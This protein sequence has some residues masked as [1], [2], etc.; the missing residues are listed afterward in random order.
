[1]SKAWL[2]DLEEKVQEAATRL[3]DQKAVSQELEQQNLKLQ[4]RVEELE[5]QLAD[6]GDGDPSSEWQEERQEIR[7]RVEKL[8]DH[9]SDLL[10]EEDS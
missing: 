9:L 4:E 8:V 7:E 10:S 6:S 1:M 3:R 2:Q 5:A